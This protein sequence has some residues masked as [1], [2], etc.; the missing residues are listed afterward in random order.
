MGT[1]E[2]MLGGNAGSRNAAE[3]RITPAVWVT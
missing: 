1:G 2:L 3:T